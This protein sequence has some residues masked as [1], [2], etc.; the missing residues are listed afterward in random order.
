[1]SRHSTAKTLA[2]IPMFKSLSSDAVKALDGRCAWRRVKA[3]EWVI[4]YQDEGIDV[5]FVVS[6]S[7]RVLIYARS[8]REVILS[9]L[10]DGGYFGELAA[11]DGKPRSAGVLAVSDA[12]VAAMP[13]RV[14]MEVLNAHPN[15]AMHVLTM[16]AARVRALDNRVLEYATLNV[17]QRIY[18]ELLRLARPMPDDLR[19]AILSPVPTHA[20]IAA[21]VSTHREAV[22]REMKLL[23]RQGCLVRRR[24]EIALTDVPKLMQQLDRQD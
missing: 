11:I 18:S 5:F 13:G 19:K 7:V 6:G 9:D 12:V 23:E 8:G 10:H 15:V 24:G 2:K 14:F 20:E 17:R 1:M 21:R 22:T 16:L 3:K 4:D